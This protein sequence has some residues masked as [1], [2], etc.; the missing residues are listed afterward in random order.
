MNSVIIDNC[1]VSKFMDNEVNVC[2]IR[3]AK[4]LNSKIDIN[5][6]PKITYGNRYEDNKILSKLTSGKLNFDDLIRN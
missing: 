4:K 3:L 5:S 6:I 2:P 1:I